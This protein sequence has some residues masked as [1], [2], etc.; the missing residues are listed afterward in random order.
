MKHVFYALRRLQ[1]KVDFIQSYVD[2][3]WKENCVVKAFMNVLP[4]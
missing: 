2:G 3:K 4:I 1:N